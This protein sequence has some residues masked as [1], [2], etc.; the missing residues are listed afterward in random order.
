[1]SFYILKSDEISG[2]VYKIG[3]TSKSKEELIHQY[4]R[5]CPSPNVLLFKTTSDYLNIE[6]YFKEKY[7]SKRL[8]CGKMMSEWIKGVKYEEFINDKIITDSKSEL[9]CEKTPDLKTEMIYQIYND[10]GEDRILESEIRIVEGVNL[11]T[12]KEII[13][14]YTKL[15]KIGII[16][17]GIGKCEAMT[18]KG[19]RCLHSAT[20]Y[21]KGKGYCRQHLEKINRS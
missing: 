16:K 21:I 15:G 20:W 14:Y 11:K 12:T 1:M 7:K 19:K 3:I 5:Y 17:K 13:D 6:N 18:F 8:G 2:D 10:S 9:E 4:S